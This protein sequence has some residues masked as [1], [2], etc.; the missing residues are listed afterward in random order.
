MALRVSEKNDPARGNTA[1]LSRE[2]AG[3]GLGW[4]INEFYPSVIS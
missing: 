4:G 1:H 3:K 2:H